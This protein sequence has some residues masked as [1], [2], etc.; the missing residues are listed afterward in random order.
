MSDSPDDS[1]FSSID[2]VDQRL[3]YNFAIWAKKGDEW[4]ARLYQETK[5]APQKQ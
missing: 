2:L 4:K 5:I 3:A 1:V